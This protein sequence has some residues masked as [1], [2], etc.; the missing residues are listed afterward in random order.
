MLTEWAHPW[1][2]VSLR[3]YREA[4]WRN[5]LMTQL[6][7]CFRRNFYFKLKLWKFVNFR[8]EMIES[9][10]CSFLLTSQSSLWC[11]QQSMKPKLLISFTVVIGRDVTFKQIFILAIK[12]LF[13]SVVKSSIS[14]F[15]LLKCFVL[16]VLVISSRCHLMFSPFHSLF[17]KHEWW[18][19]SSD[20]PNNL[21][22]RSRR[23]AQNASTHRGLTSKIPCAIWATLE[24]ISTD[25]FHHFYWWCVQQFS[26]AV[27][28][29]QFEEAF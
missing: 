9:A 5:L 27:L 7:V 17:F 24:V 12:S 20:I 1:R 28:Q 14:F 15:S 26:V 3:L 2:F 6:W 29:S 23:L 18:T 10:L 19:A 4:I 22:E 11:V 13:L 21:K 8:Q 16:Q 25:F